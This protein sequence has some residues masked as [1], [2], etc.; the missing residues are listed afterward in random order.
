MVKSL[1]RCIQAVQIHIQIQMQMQEADWRFSQNHM[2]P[3]YPT[4]LK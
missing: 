3:S 4:L 2:L 1:Q